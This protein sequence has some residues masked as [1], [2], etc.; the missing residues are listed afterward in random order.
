MV[1]VV[2]ESA[3]ATAGMLMPIA[4]TRASAVMERAGKYFIGSPFT[5]TVPTVEN[6]IVRLM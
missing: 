4:L 1:V 6:G 2:V 3:N 5:R